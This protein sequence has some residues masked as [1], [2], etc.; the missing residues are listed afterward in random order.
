MLQ[1][2]TQDNLTDVLRIT[3]I[4]KLGRMNADDDQLIRIFCLK[5][6]QFRDD[7]NTVDAAVGPKVEQDNLALELGHG[8][9]TIRV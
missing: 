3:F 7:V 9:W 2:I 5:P 4:L 8:K 6:S 1:P